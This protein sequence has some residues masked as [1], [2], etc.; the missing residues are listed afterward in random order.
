MS[1]DLPDDLA[2]LLA[3]ARTGV[4]QPPAELQARVLARVKGTVAGGPGSGGEGGGGGVGAGGGAVSASGAS[5]LTPVVV[6]V[7]IAGV[8]GGWLLSQ[9]P[10][11][12]PAPPVTA[13]ADT[14]G[15]PTAEATTPP[16]PT[17]AVV[18]AA[19]DEPPPPVTARAVAPAIEKPTPVAKASATPSETPAP[20]AK[21]PA[22]LLAEEEALLEQARAALADGD[23]HG[24]IEPLARHERHHPRGQLVEEREALWIRASLR[25]GDGEGARRRA[26]A[27]EADF[28][29]TIH[30][31]V[32]EEARRTR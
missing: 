18:P 1:D 5:W 26:D 6:V 7:A 21:E 20:V 31:D 22:D 9:R 23:A 32:I 27:L 10:A 28:P 17:P 13:R 15:A 16:A 3:D 14:R 8:G 2:R 19:V 25:A 11:R 4:P 30:R 29:K 12:H 24:A